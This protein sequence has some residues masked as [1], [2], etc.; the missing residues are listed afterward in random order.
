MISSRSPG[1]RCLAPLALAAVLMAACQD[2]PRLLEPEL[3]PVH[4]PALDAG[5][6]A[7]L[8]VA[9]DDALSRLIP[10]DGAGSHALREALLTL[11]TS[12][13]DADVATLESRLNEVREALAADAIEPADADALIL[14]LD[15]VG[16]ARGRT[17]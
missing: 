9:F 10:V 14:A 1:R 17:D 6:A 11:T 8:A 13:A 3:N 5:A 12:L 4:E 7:L 16:R 2:T 15:A